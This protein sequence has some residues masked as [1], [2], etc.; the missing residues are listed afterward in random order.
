MQSVSCA[1]VSGNP[2]PPLRR[3]SFQ[4][5]N[6]DLYF[7]DEDVVNLDDYVPQGESNPHDTRPWF[8]H[9]AG[10]CIG[11][12]FADCLQDA[13]DIAADEGRL[14]RFLLA[15][16]DWV[17]YDGP[18]DERVSYLGNHGHPYDIEA[19]GVVELPNPPVSFVALFNAREGGTS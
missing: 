3:A 10:F 19:L 7:T 11:V 2:A 14:E 8:L 13:L 18:D 5:A 15:D 4:V 1:G 9:D 12:V 17:D 6:C 16:E